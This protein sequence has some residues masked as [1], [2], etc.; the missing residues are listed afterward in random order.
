M[1]KRFAKLSKGEQE[2]VEEEYHKMDPHE[3]DTLMARALPYRPKVKP[4]PKSR[5]K[6]VQKRRRLNPQ[7]PR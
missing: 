3:F 2:K 6:A 5:A 7:A 1:K 4:N